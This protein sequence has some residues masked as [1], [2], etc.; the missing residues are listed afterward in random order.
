M[1]TSSEREI[2][3]AKGRK[4]NGHAATVAA[5]EA[6][7]RLAAGMLGYPPEGATTVPPAPGDG[8]G[9]TADQKN[10]KRVALYLRVSTD[11]QNTD[12][13]EHELREVAAR[14]GWHITRIY[15]D[16]GISGAKGRDKRPAYDAM[17]NAATRRELD[18]VAAWNVDRLSRS[19]KD[20]VTFM[21]D[22]RAVGCDIYIHQQHLDTS[23][24]TG[25]MVFQVMGSIAEYERAIIIGRVKAGMSRARREG[26]HMGR[27]RLPEPKRQAIIAELRRGTGVKKTAALHEVGVLTV[28][29]IKKE[30][31][32]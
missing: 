25:R 6:A 12:N 23:T 24:P 17:C 27:P 5:A 28:Q 13:Q 21:D 9:G 29:R 2:D 16:A 32:E 3:M 11:E 8:Q 4:V 7:A 1:C 19:L 10:K 22:M 14:A 15:R 30:I 20:L 18:V 31:A 26:K